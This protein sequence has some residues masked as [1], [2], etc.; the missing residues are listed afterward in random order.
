MPENKKNSGKKS[1]PNT[2]F[3]PETA[4]RDNRTAAGAAKPL[5]ARTDEYRSN[6]VLNRL[7]DMP[8]RAMMPF[9]HKQETEKDW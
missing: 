8:G 5:Q 1:A 2:F 6:N 9:Y 7:Q 3:K 4:A